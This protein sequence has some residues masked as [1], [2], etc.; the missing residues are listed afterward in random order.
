MWCRLRG[1]FAVPVTCM[2]LR[3]LEGIV[4]N[5]SLNSLGCGAGAGDL[6]GVDARQLSVDSGRAVHV[7]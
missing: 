5:H 4:M 6:C 3:G 7:N 1:G 2:N